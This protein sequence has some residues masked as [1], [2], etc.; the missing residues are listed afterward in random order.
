MCDND[1]SVEDKV[2]RGYN[3]GCGSGSA[4]IRI[5]FISWIRIQRVN[6]EGKTEKYKKINDNCT[7]I[8]KN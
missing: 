6:F 5:H 8:Y 2:D 4:W 7:F 1:S 3:Q